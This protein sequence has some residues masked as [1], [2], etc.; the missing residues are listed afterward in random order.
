MLLTNKHSV[1]TFTAGALIETNQTEHETEHKIFNY[2]L[3]LVIPALVCKN[4]NRKCFALG[5]NNLN[6]NLFI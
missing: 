5:L 2:P 1:I 3:D 6:D 4:L